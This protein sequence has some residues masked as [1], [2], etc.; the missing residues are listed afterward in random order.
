[1]QNSTDLTNKNLISKKFIQIL[2][3]G[4][5]K[6]LDTRDIDYEQSV[7]KTYIKSNTKYKIDYRII[8]PRR[9]PDLEETYANLVKLFDI[10]K[11]QSDIQPLDIKLTI[12]KN[13]N[14]YG[15]AY[16]LMDPL[17][18]H[19]LLDTFYTDEKEYIKLNSPY[20]FPQLDI[21]FSPVVKYKNQWYSP[22]FFSLVYDNIT[23]KITKVNIKNYKANAIHNIIAD[24]LL[25]TIS[26]YPGLFR[27]I[28]AL[29]DDPNI[30]IYQYYVNN[31]SDTLSMWL[32]S[33]F[34]IPELFVNWDDLIFS[35]SVA[36]S[37]RS[38]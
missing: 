7:L 27:F 36:F 30:F 19:I 35:W 4:L 25:N 32:H 16:I 34:N 33:I 14:V 2:T 23:R 21:S 24:E 22:Q 12:E 20:F 6:L 8:L 28:S 17:K 9:G 1:M 5:T 37:F 18:L 10:S 15:I 38:L 13:E 31:T 11:Y 3:K 29:L 26:Q